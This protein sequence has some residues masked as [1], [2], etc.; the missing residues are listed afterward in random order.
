MWAGVRDESAQ[1]PVELALGLLRSAVA[2]GR[3]HVPRLRESAVTF[4]VE[5]ASG[6][7]DYF[8]LF[9]TEGEV[10]LVPGAAPIEWTGRLVTVFAHEDAVS[11]LM[12]GEPLAGADVYGD[13]QVLTELA[14]CLE[15][16]HDLYSV[17]LFK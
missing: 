11:R 15:R 4:A 16:G 1:V 10:Q 12:D 2:A 14:P 5:R 8:T 7:T 13:A 6:L 9:V 17:R 3:A